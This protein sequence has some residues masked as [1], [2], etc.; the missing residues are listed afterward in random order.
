MHIIKNFNRYDKP[1]AFLDLPH[2]SIWW[3]SPHSD[4]CLWL[5]LYFVASSTCGGPVKN[6][7]NGGGGVRLCRERE[8][9]TENGNSAPITGGLCLKRVVF[10]R[11]RAIRFPGV[12]WVLTNLSKRGRACAYLV[13]Y[14][15]K[16][17]MA[18]ISGTIFFQMYFIFV[19]QDFNILIHIS[20][21][22][23]LLNHLAIIW[24]WFR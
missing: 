12:R 5:Q 4:W 15:E 23:I 1:W 3:I 18:D 16:V 17:Q 9:L 10:C 24:H 6:T 20:L 22:F 19:C 8:D 21:R 14:Q 11:E 13:W 2:D 7:E